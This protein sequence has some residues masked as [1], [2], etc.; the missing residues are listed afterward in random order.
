MASVTDMLATARQY[1]QARQFQRAEEAYRQVLQ[2][3]PLHV[4]A[5][6]L[7]GELCLSTG[8]FADAAASFLEALRLKPDLAVASNSLG[9]VYVHQRKLQEA[10]DRFRHAVQVQPGLVQAHNN[11]GNVLREQGRFQEA[12][13]S[14]KAALQLKP[15]FAEV[16][17]NLGNVYR[18]LG[19]LSKAAAGYQQA[20]R[21][22]PNYPEAH[23]NLGH[24]L[25]QMGQ[26]QN[27]IVCFQQALRLRPDFA[28]AHSNLGIAYLQLGQTGDAVASCRQGVMHQPSLPEAHHHLGV[29]LA[30]QGRLADAVLSFQE[31]LRL[32]PN[33]F[34]A[35][36]DRGV[37]YAEQGTLEEALAS[38]REAVRIVP[39]YAEALNNQ[40]NVL[41]EQG[42]LDE[43]LPCFQ[44]A[45][46]LRPAHMAF[47]SNLL[48][49]LHYHE[50]FDPETVFREHCRW[51]K[52]H[53]PALLPAA[54]PFAC[55]RNPDRPLH[56]GYV[57]P[58]FRNHVV[59]FFIEPVLAGHDPQQF[60]F[61]AYANVLRPDVTTQRLE[62]LADR[63]RNIV[64][65]SDAEACDL[66]RSDG[67]DILVD[68]AGHS[69]NNRVTLF[70]RKPA[71]IQ[72]AHFGYPNTTGL[73]A[74][75]YRITDAKADP[76]GMTES[77]YT[78]QLVRLPEIAWCYQPSTS[79]EVG[80][81][82]ARQAGHVTFGSLNNLTKV[83][84]A[85]IALWARIMHAAPGAKLM[86]LTQPGGRQ[87]LLE[88]FQRHGVT[89]ERLLLVGKQTRDK[90]LELYNAIDIGLDPFPYN[91]G[92]TT[93][94]ALWMGVPVITLAGNAYVSRQG[95]SLL[96]NVHLPELI[97]AT[98]DDYVAIA[99]RLANDL[100]GLEQMRASLRQHMARSPVVDGLSFTRRLQQAYREMWRRWCAQ[101]PVIG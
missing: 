92:V 46:A 97:A 3:D 58:D 63:W 13:Q 88:A 25:Q 61:F 84:P 76:P 74:I 91:G 44:Q 82:P 96:T 80:A 28:L 79:P 49:A 10:S 18:D 68:L 9:I 33:Y 83:T 72:V 12:L 59:A 94:D 55:D 77:W 52:Q 6:F 78:E 5:W 16:H 85:V 41:K 38:F 11:L 66:I 42:R 45:V 86:L 70:A 26:T 37:A 64:G 50:N 17:N 27:A 56:V 93:C 23:N 43:A 87:R 69:A 62:A 100:S 51:A 67:I 22:K 73:T 57:S 30:G 34:E 24:A 75:D 90:Y 99:Q 19:E 101:T 36:N 53:L 71:P 48:F 2:S 39:T 47:H 31:A 29:A 20:L 54:R 98:T 40:G 89:P 15:D 1:Q 95:V 60:Q 7:L 4:E 32:K 81:L 21:L 8:K 14:Y 65:L 35:F